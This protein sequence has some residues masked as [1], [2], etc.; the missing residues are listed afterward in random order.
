MLASVLHL[1]SPQ[2]PAKDRTAPLPPIAL[3]RSSQRLNHQNTERKLRTPGTVQCSLSA[4]SS[5]RKRKRSILKCAYLRSSLE[6]LIY[7]WTFSLLTVTHLNT[8]LASSCTR[9]TIWSILC[10]S[11]TSYS[12]GFSTK[13]PAQGATRFIAALERDLF[14]V[15]STGVIIYT[16][17]V[18]SP[19]AI[20]ICFTCFIVHARVSC[21]PASTPG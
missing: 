18:V 10:L 21:S 17:P 11:V 20:M 14:C 1:D 2:E 13:L 7:L 15:A 6:S 9:V 8:W 3:R 19:A 5:S 4:Y 12:S 16:S